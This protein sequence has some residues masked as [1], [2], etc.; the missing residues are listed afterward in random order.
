MYMCVGGK[1]GCEECVDVGEMCV[2]VGGQGVRV[3]CVGVVWGCCVCV[4]VWVRCV[5]VYVCAVC[6]LCVVCTPH[7]G[8][9]L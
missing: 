7:C 2:W 6:V 4:H 5:C 9:S 3:L 1:G 8:S